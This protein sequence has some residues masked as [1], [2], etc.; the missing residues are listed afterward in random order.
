MSVQG[1]L[2][3]SPIGLPDSIADIDTAIAPDSTHF[4]DFK[5]DWSYNFNPSTLDFTYDSAPVVLIAADTGAWS[6]AESTVTAVDTAG[7][8]SRYRLSLNGRNMTVRYAIDTT[9]DWTWSGA[10]IVAKLN[11]VITAAKP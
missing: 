5:T 4:I 1:T 10:V 6:V 11:V 3:I 7:W 2:R 8:I 9:M